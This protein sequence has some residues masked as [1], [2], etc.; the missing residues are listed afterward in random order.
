MII[1]GLL[2]LVFTAFLSGFLGALLHEGTHWIIARIWT[3]EVTITSSYSK[4]PLPDRTSF[5]NPWDLPDYGVRIAGIAPIV[6]VFLLLYTMSMYWGRFTPRSIVMIFLFLGASIMSF[7]DMMAFLFPERW[8]ELTD[9][10][11][12]YNQR[13]MA[14]LLFQEL[15]KSL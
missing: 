6:Y 15:R 3:R 7:H 1:V 11:E 8:R 2:L 5:E 10:D 14:R 4:V 13:E 9:S 12:D